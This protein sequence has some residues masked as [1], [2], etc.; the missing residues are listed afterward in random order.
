MGAPTAPRRPDVGSRVRTRYVG[1][2][3]EHLLTRLNALDFINR[4]MLLAA[5]LLLC[6]FPFFITYDALAGRSA[7]Q[8]LVRHLGLN[9]QAAFIVTSVFAPASHTSGAMTG[10]A[11]VFFVLS[12]IAAAAAVQELYESAFELPGAGMKGRWRAVIWVAVVAGAATVASWAGPRI[13]AAGGR[14]LLAFVY[15]VVLTGFWWFT[16]WFLLAGR[17]R[18]HTLLPAALATAVCWVGM[19]F[20]FS[21]FFSDAVISDYN[22]YGPIGVVFALMSWLIAIGVVLIIGAAFGLVWD[23]R[24][25]DSPGSRRSRRLHRRSPP[26]DPDGPAATTG[27]AATASDP[28]SPR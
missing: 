15:L 11:W 1:S 27:P 6:F 28:L 12:G 10:T 5:V 9:A 20:A 23:E 24:H 18:W 26:P 13:H 19:E 14:F 3:A 25:P 17:I 7:V 21:L 22:K 8:A 16:I 2:S 4:G